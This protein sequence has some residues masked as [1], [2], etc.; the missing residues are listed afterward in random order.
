MKEFEIAALPGTTFREGP[1]SPIDLLAISPQV[2]FDQFKKT[3]EIFTFSLEHL[4]VQAGEN[5]IPVKAPGR[6]VYMPMGLET[7]FAA[8]SQLCDW[9]MANVILPVFPAS[10]E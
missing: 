8:L 7:N 1:C 6:E 3:K 9:Y 4:E 2:D 5:W 10:A